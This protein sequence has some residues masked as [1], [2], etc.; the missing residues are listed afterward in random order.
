MRA[1]AAETARLQPPLPRL[2]A[3]PDTFQRF[4]HP[5]AQIHR[6]LLQ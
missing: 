6:R 2:G 5:D 4:D 1:D 3:G